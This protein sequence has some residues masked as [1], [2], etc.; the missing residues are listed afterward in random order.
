VV[1]DGKLL[2]SFY[3]RVDKAQ[4][5]CFTGGE[6]EL[7]H[8][9]VRCALSASSERAVKIHLAVDEIVV[10]VRDC[11]RASDILDNRIIV[12]M[13]VVILIGL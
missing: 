5:V 2:E 12:I 1:V 7:R 6:L 4:P 11:A 13:E 9:S 8:T 3:S 10:R